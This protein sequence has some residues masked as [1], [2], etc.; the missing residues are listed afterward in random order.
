MARMCARF[1][2]H[3]FA[4]PEYLPTTSHMQAKLPH[5]VAYALHRTKLHPSVTFA[6]LIL[7]QRLKARFLPSKLRHSDYSL[8][9]ILIPNP[10]IPCYQHYSRHVASISVQLEAFTR[11]SRRNF[12]IIIDWK[13]IVEVSYEMTVV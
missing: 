10:R 7:L 3:L 12:K 5:F 13:C 6:S 8:S 2:T 1:I 9:L 4:C 11:L